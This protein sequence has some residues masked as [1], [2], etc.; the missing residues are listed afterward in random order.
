MRICW[1][2]PAVDDLTVICDYLQEHESPALAQRVAQTVY[3]AAQSLSQFPKKGRP[4]R[5]PDTR[6]LV[7]QRYPYIVV[8]RVRADAVEIIRV[9]H[10]SQRWP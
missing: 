6:E 4:G 5:E 7:I 1:T 9:L 8:Y 2:Q 3:G 10:T